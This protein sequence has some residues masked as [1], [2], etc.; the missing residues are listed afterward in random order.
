VKSRHIASAVTTFKWILVPVRFFALLLPEPL[1]RHHEH[2]LT[3]R[4][5]LKVKRIQL[6]NSEN[7][8]MTRLCRLMTLLTCLVL[9]TGTAFVSSDQHA[10]VLRKHQA[11]RMSGGG[12]D[13]KPP[14]ELYQGAVAAGAAKASAP[15]GKIFKLG[16]VSGCHIGFGAYLAI[17]VGG[18]CPGIAAENPGLQKIIM[19]A[20][21]LPFG[22]IMTLVSGGELFT[23]N[24]ALVTAAQQ[25]G[26]ITTKDLAKNWIASYLGNFVGSVILAY[27]AYKSGTLGAAP[28]AASMAVAKCSSAWEATFVKGILCNW[29]VCM[30]VYMASGCSSM[31]GKMTAVWFPISAFVALGLEHSVANMFMIPLG[32]LRGADITMKQMFVTNLIPVTLGN[33]VGGAVAVMMPFGTTFGSWGKKK[34]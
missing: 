30:A 20:F 28:G 31:I 4:A 22:L 26:K 5:H 21:G 7:A 10:S 6:S 1:D 27:L 17:S 14:A 29:L 24:T 3:D 11:L 33:I 19:G 12:S 13:L 2:F 32:I 23:G 18:A 34:E 15:F 9:S 25:E 16:I 8:I